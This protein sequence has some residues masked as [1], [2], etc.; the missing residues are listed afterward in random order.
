MEISPEIAEERRSEP[1]AF[2]T[3]L[4]QLSADSDS[5]NNISPWSGQLQPATEIFFD[6]GDIFHSH[7]DEKSNLRFRRKNEGLYK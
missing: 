1:S 6:K 4:G 3:A 5:S 2:G 7:C